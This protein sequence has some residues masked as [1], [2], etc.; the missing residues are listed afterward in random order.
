MGTSESLFYNNIIIRTS[1]LLCFQGLQ[2]LIF[3]CAKENDLR[4]MTEPPKT[5]EQQL[6][7]SVAIFNP[8]Y[9][10]KQKQVWTTCRENDV[11]K[12]ITIVVS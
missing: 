2:Q 5:D 12:T 7:R 4:K 10:G 6:P 9:Y 1:N 3:F 11:L 8:G